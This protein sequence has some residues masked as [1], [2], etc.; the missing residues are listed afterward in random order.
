VILPATV[1]TEA[2]RKIAVEALTLHIEHLDQ[3]DGAHIG[4]AKK[5][6]HRVMRDLVSSKTIYMFR[7]ERLVLTEALHRLNRTDQ[8][9]KRLLGKLGEQ[10]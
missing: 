3:Q 7:Q 5:A 4:P 2:Q 9:V 6:G 10:T 1:F 8:V